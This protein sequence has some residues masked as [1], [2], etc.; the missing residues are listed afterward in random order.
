MPH[1]K[2]SKSHRRWPIATALRDALREG[3]GRRDFFADLASGAVVGVIAIPLSMALAIACNVPPQHG[4]YTAIIAG[5][6]SALC[7]GSRFQVSGP[8]AAFV[9]ILAPIVS[10]HGFAG[11]VIATQMAGLILLLIGALRLG[12]LI[13]FVPHPV[14]TGFTAG[15]AVVIATIQMKDFFGLEIARMPDE[16]GHKLA[17]LWHAAPGFSPVETGVA[18]ATLALLLLL[19]KLEHR[20]PA[21]LVV[22]PI[23]SVAGWYINQ[24]LGE[25]A[26]DTIATRFSY[27]GTGG[28]LPGIPPFPPPLVLP[29]H[30]PGADGA[31]FTPTLLVIESLV[32][33]AFAIALL[34]GIE[35]L[36]SAV[37]SDGMTGRKHDPNAELVGQGL[38]NLAAT[39]FGGF[40]STGAIARTTANI[41]FGGRSPI[42]ALVHALVIL[43]CVVMIA[44]WL[45]YLP[46]ASMAALLL[47]V[48]WNMS[49]LP[50]FLHVGRIAPRSDIAVQLA[51]FGLTVAFDMVVAVTAGMML[52][53]LL[54]M[55]RM[56]DVASVRLMSHESATLERSLPR[57]VL[58]YEIAGPLFFGAAE[59]AMSALQEVDAELRVVIFDLSHV[60]AMDVT[61]LINLDSALKRLQSRGVEVH[62]AGVQPQ[63]ARLIA[64]A[65][66]A[67]QGRMPEI[68]PTLDA[69]LQR[70]ETV[71]A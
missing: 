56:S 19:P 31:P 14:T 60:P 35:S 26:V 33:A 40:A 41:R 39:L 24:R 38:G 12:R 69:A 5:A 7:G 57:G 47:I 70:V 44:P 63:P 9:V 62:F 65:E 22:L 3:Y 50:H 29:W 45:G 32:P 11:L 4:L 61:G 46:M 13:E 37:V 51:C 54:F 18:V 34:G 64:R 53:S 21:P 52:A 28:M 59:K 10:E 8:T 42:A 49:D 30:W 36:L 48:A 66:W 23:M 6:V 16:Y 55:K 58:V 2:H 43:G 15:I 25:G 68:H 17:A 71:S 67:E 20:V 27:T 1:R